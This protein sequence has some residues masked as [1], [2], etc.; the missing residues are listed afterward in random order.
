MASN[1]KTPGR[2]GL[3]LDPP[4]F[5]PP[6]E[7]REAYLRRRRDELGELRQG[8]GRGDWLLVRITANHVRGTGAMYGFPDIG[9]A[10]DKLA[11]ALQNEDSGCRDCLE[12]YVRAVNESSL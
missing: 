2:S 8:A 4:A 6:L 10:A 11:D 5:A 1:G 12:N 3:V 9:S 7:M